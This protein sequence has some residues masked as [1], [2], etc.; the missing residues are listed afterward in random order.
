MI[1]YSVWVLPP[2]EL[3]R[4]IDELHRHCRE[5]IGGPGII[6]HVTVAGG[7]DM[8]LGDFRDLVQTAVGGFQP[9]DM[10]LSGIATDTYFFRS[11]FLHARVSN[12]V[13]RLRSRIYEL[14]HAPEPDYHPHASLYYGDAPLER[15]QA[16]A[17]SL[18]FAASTCPDSKLVIA[19]NNE[20]DLDWGIV[21]AVELNQK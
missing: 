8:P 4:K 16:I 2:V 11:L 1:T 14:A 20:T 9:G 10:T 12:A 13:R 19:F 6:P 3:A 7:V 17:Q 18:S 5:S 21:E 15:R